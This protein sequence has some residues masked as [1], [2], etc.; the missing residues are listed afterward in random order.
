MDLLALVALCSSLFFLEFQSHSDLLG[1]GNVFPNL[2][3]FLM[4]AGN[5]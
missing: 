1:L 4:V 3:G 5:K 2:S